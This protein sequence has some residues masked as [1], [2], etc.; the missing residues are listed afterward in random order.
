MKSLSEKLIVL[1]HIPGGPSYLAL[2]V[3]FVANVVLSCS[4]FSVETSQFN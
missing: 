4:V 1:K 3:V 2:Y